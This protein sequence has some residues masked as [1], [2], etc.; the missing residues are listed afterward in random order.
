MSD[1]PEIPT[2]DLRLFFAIA[3]GTT[4]LLQL[5][6]ILVQRGIISGSIGPYMPLVVFG[7]FVPTIAALVLGRRRPGGMRALVRQFATFRVLPGWYFVAAAHPAAILMIGM[8]LARF[9]GG[10]EMGKAFYPPGA[11]Q[12][13]AMVVIPFT[14]QLPWRGFV[15]PPLEQRIGPLAASVVTGA[16]WGLFHLQKQSLFGAGLTL[17]VALWLLLLMTAGTVVYTWIYRRTGSMLL[18]VVA[19]AGIYLDNPVQAL[20]ANVVPLAVHALGYCAGAVLLLALD[21][22]S[23]RTIA[24]PVAA[25]A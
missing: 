3:F 6:A 23:W 10:P 19:N 9:V 13:V 8:G 5:P 1:A 24:P 11:A 17:D 18:V 16:A 20:P 2:R 15:Y 12:V 22:P 25:T 14:E 4:W 21:R 7:Y